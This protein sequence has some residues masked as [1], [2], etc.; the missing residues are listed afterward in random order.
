MNRVSVWVIL[1]MSLLLVTGTIAQPRVNLPSPR[2]LPPAFP[3]GGPFLKKDTPTKPGR[4]GA[5]PSTVFIGN[6]G[7]LSVANPARQ[8]TLSGIDPQPESIESSIPQDPIEPVTIK[9]GVSNNTSLVVDSLP[10]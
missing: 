2:T 9:R 3:R 8:S 1:G 7:E 6:G 5:I 10:F 4:A